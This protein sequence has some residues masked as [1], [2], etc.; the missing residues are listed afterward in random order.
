MK[1]LGHGMKV[2]ESV[3]EKRLRRIVSDDEVQFGFVPEKGTIDAVFILRTQEEYHAEG[4]M[5]YVCFVDLEKAFHSVQRKVLEWAMRK[6]GM[7]EIVF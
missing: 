7:P 4:N 5:L 3:F 6:I 2:V 1:L